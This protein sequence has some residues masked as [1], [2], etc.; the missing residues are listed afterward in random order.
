MLPEPAL[1][2]LQWGWNV[3]TVFDITA[4]FHWNQA[5]LGGGFNLVSLLSIVDPYCTPASNGSC[6]CGGSCRGTSYLASST[7]AWIRLAA[8][9]EGVPHVWCLEM[10]RTKLAAA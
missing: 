9:V 10:H 4:V 8:R 6:A 5:T 1:F 3:S 7:A 2:D